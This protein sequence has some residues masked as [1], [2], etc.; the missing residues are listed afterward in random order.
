VT[1]LIL[2]DAQQIFD[3]RIELEPLAFALAAKHARSGDTSI[4]SGIV[5]KTKLKATAEDLGGFFES[6][7]EFRKKVWEISGN[8]YLRQ[9]L[10][11]VVVSLYALYLIRRSYNGEGVLQTVSE[12]VEHQ[13]RIMDAFC[14]NDSESAR[15]TAKDFLIRMKE[16]LGTCLVPEAPGPLA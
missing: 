8:R 7:L 4:L 10:E 3:V 13:D 12:C 14:R 1:T 6:H 16:Y 5:E 11:R 9:A 2:G 15:Q